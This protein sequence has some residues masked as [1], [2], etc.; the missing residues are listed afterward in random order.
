MSYTAIVLD[1]ESQQLLLRRFQTLAKPYAHHMTVMLG[2]KPQDI[3]RKAPAF[4][5]DDI[6]KLYRLQVVGVGS[7]KQIEAV[8]VVLVKEDGQL[9]SDGI[10]QKLFPHITV[11]TD[12]LTKPFKS[13]EMLRAGFEVNTDGLV[14]T[15]T[16]R[17]V[18]DEK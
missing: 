18:E 9:L 12:G 14:L 15:G 13:D 4:S 10:S 5:A 17:F 6:G 1:S 7:S 11:A 16:L 3:A 2:V 8:V